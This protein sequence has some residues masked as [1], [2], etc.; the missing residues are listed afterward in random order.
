MLGLLHRIGLLRTP[1]Q[2]FLTPRCG[3]ADEDDNRAFDCHEPTAAEL[4]DATAK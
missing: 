4:D 3:D 1:C 2:W